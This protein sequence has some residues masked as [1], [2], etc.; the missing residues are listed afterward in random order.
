MERTEVATYDI[1]D[2]TGVYKF[3]DS[4]GEILYIGKAT[5]L[6]DRVKS[7]F[8]SDLG[9]SRGAR[10]VAMVAQA[11]ALEW[12]VTDSVLEALILEANLIKEKQPPYNVDE[13]DNKSFNYLIVT[14]EDFPR[15]LIIRGRELY[16]PEGVNL[17][18]KKIFGP[19]PNGL[20]EALKIIRRIFP[21]RDTCVPQSAKAC[22]N[23]QI[24]LCPGVCS[25]NMT[26]AEYA[27]RIADICELFA[28]NFKGL[29]RDLA[30]KMKEA[31]SLERFERAIEYRRQI[32][33]LEHIRDVSLIK[34]EHR[35]A[36]GGGTRIEAYDVAHTSGR[37]TVA[38]MTVVSNGEP[39][40][41]AYRKF[42]IHTVENNDVGA[43]KEVLSRRLVHTEWPLP[44]VFVVD[45]GKGQLNAARGIL[46]DAGIGIALVGVVKN[47][48]HQPE[49]LIG[50]ERSIAAH[51]KDILLANAEA[52]RFAI[53]WHRKRRQKASL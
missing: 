33:A 24:G 32:E 39:V 36:P 38:V 19:F 16:G 3:L 41:S 51:Q 5:S 23:R 22:F 46:K 15:V 44:R 49:R 10:I 42:K 1:P 14:K 8:S 28:G 27:E 12:I 21:Y 18:I 48:R 9:K 29:K 26:K 11:V 6:H 40:K 31:A 2:S 47:A 52:H 43:L 17:A 35:I 53:S 50:N 20:K 34:E 37:E 7:Y 13:K 30:R 45:G 25:G 4:K